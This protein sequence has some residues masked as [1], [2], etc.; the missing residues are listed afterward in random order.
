MSGVEDRPALAVLNGPESGSRIPLD[1][2]T[3]IGSDPRCRVRVAGASP[4]HA[5]VQAQGQ[6]Y[7]LHDSGSPAGVW[8][9]DD[10]VSGSRRL[11][12]GDIVWLGS[13]GAP[14][15]VMLQCKFPA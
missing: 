14:A 12:D 11:R 15:S 8:V 1:A 9:N 13:P 5:T 3:L 2:E 10:R 6:E 4:I 7:V